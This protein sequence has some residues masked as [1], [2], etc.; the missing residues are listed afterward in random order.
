MGL[1]VSFIHCNG[2]YLLSWIRSRSIDLESLHNFLE[3]DVAKSRSSIEAS[4]LHLN[5]PTGTGT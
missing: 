1:V 3:E 5:I 4:V 2:I